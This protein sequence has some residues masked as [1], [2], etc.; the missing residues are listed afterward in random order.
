MFM[1]LIIELPKKW[2]KNWQ[3][4]KETDKFTIMVRDFSALSQ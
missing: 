2:N 4:A 1:Y 3:T